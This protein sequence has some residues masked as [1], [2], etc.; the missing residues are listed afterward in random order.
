MSVET[1]RTTPS[2]RSWHAFIGDE[3][4]VTNDPME[5]HYIGFNMWVRRSKKAGTTDVDAV[6]EAM[7]GPEGAEPDRRLLRD[8][9]EPP[10]HQAGADR[11]DPGRRPVRDRLVRPTDLVV[12]D[13]W[14]D[15]LPG[16][17]QAD[18][19][20]DAPPGL[21]QLQ[22]RSTGKCGG[23][24]ARP[25]GRSGRRGCARFGR[26]GEPRRRISSERRLARARPA[27]P[28]AYRRARRLPLALLCW[29]VV[30]RAAPRGAPRAEPRRRWLA[31][32]GKSSTDRAAIAA[33]AA[34]GDPRARR[35]SRR[36]SKGGSSFAKSDGAVVIA[37]KS[38]KRLS[39]LDR[40]V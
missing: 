10:H 18:R 21:R 9:A 8:D 6:R 12:G 24:G 34:S 26:P 40:C 13:A 32:D 4:R 38:G 5:A 22:H 19:R 2:S 11:R 31:C 20:L 3:E 14:S 16:K 25:S 7:Y 39:L 37:E 30:A 15:Y 28:I 29:R 27:A 1:T 36:C 23:K 33:L 35:S 17:R